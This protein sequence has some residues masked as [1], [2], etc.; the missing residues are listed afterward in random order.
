MV[1]RPYSMEATTLKAVAAWA[2]PLFLSPLGLIIAPAFASAQ[3]TIPPI[4]DKPIANT[5]E[6]LSDQPVPPANTSPPLAP[7]TRPPQLPTTAEG[8]TPRI[9]LPQPVVVPNGADPKGADTKGADTKGADNGNVQQVVIPLSGEVRK[10]IEE[11]LRQPTK[12]QRG[13]PL[14]PTSTGDPILDDVLQVIRNRGSV[15]DGSSLDPQADLEATPQPPSPNRTVRPAPP[16]PLPQ[17]RI[18]EFPDPQTYPA[19]P[20][21]G[22]RG[23]PRYG[24]S[25]AGQPRPDSR[26]VAAEALLRAARLLADVPATD[27]GTAA[28]I[29]AMRERAAMLLIDQFTPDPNRLENAP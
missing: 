5:A 19:E 27:E 7:Q 9:E 22:Y 20:L 13:N 15:L 8:T 16:R 24:S 17:A 28:L 6:K 25:D 11:A 18:E 2:I 10:R 29:G 3:T 23:E 21:S 12:D 14:P 4:A 26:F 1:M